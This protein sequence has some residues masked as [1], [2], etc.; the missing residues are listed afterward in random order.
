[1]KI[2]RKGLIAIL[3]VAMVIG[4]SMMAYAATNSES[5]PVGATQAVDDYHL[6]LKED[7]GQPYE[8][9]LIYT[10][11]FMR[12]SGTYETDYDMTGGVYSVQNWVTTAAPTFDVTISP[13]S[14]EGS[15]STVLM[16]IYLEK[17]NGNKWEVV[18]EGDVTL[19]YGGSVSL[20]GDTSGTYRLYFRNWSGF[21]AKGKIYVS[22][23]Y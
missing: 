12:A 14:F 10:N 13:T 5:V 2:L 3:S 6:D 9:V 19:K 7:N 8:E 15:S 21:R 20:S 18:D 22:Y 17:K 1:M 4:V 11:P 16:T 23:S